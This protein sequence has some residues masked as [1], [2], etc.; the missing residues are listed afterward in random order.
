MKAVF[1]IT[2]TLLALGLNAQF[3]EQWIF[4]SSAGTYTEITAGTILGTAVEGSVGAASLDDVL[5]VLPENT[6][7]WMFEFDGEYYTGLTASTNGQ[8]IIGGSTY[9][10]HNPLSSTVVASGCVAL[11]ARDL[12]GL[13][14]AGTLGEMRYE[15]VGTAPLREFV[16]Q[17]KNF[18]K[19]GTA[20]NNESYNFQLRLQETTNR[21]RIVYGTMTVNTTN[22]S[23][24]VGL[25]GS[26]N[27]DYMGRTTTTDWTQSTAATVNNATMTLTTAVAPTSGLQYDFD[28]AAPSNPPNPAIAIGPIDGTQNVPIQQGLAWA[29][30]GGQTLGYK[31]SFGTDNPPTNIE[32][33]TDLGNVF[34]YQ[35]ASVLAYDTDYFWI[36]VPF[37]EAGDTQNVP[38]WSFRTKPDPTIYQIPYYQSF[39]SPPGALPTDW[40]VLVQGNAS[41]SMDG[42]YVT[43]NITDQADPGLICLSAP[44]LDEDL[45]LTNLRLRFTSQGGGFI[46]VGMISDPYSL[47]SFELIQRIAKPGGTSWIEYIIHFDQYSGTNRMPAFIV[48]EYGSQTIDNVYIETRPLNDLALGTL[49]GNYNPHVGIGE[50]YTLQIR[51]LGTN[52]QTQYQVKLMNGP[53]EL[54]TLPGPPLAPSESALIRIPWTPSNAGNHSLKGVITP[55]QDEV[56]VNN[57]T[58]VMPVSVS[59]DPNYTFVLGTGASYSNYPINLSNRASKY[60]VIIPGQN[61]GTPMSIFALT[62]YSFFTEAAPGSHVKLWLANTTQS[63]LSQ[64]FI[65]VEDFTLVFDGTMNFAMGVNNVF[66]PFAELPQ[67][68]QYTG[69]NL[70]LMAYKSYN[71]LEYSDQNRFA[72]FDINWGQAR[73][74]GSSLDNINPETQGGII[75][76]KAPKIAFHASAELV[77]LLRGALLDLNNHPIPGVTIQLTGNPD[78]VTNQFGAFEFDYLTEGPYTISCSVTGYENYSQQLNIPAGEVIIHNISPEPLFSVGTVAGF[79]KNIHGVAIAGALLQNEEFYTH[80]DAAGNYVLNLPVGTGSITVTAGDYY[81]QTISNVI[82]QEN[83]TTTLNITMIHPTANDDQFAGVPVTSISGNFPN[84]FNPST[85]IEFN[86]AKASFTRLEIYNVKGQL[87]RTLAREELRTGKYELV[88]N[89]RDDTGCEVSSG[90]YF[91]KLSHDGKS[92]SRKMMLMK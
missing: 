23:P 71:V 79:V 59:N 92:Y 27:A 19:Y 75:V 35:P 39:N 64:G 21:I 7:P 8:V 33:A 54:V 80:S 73:Y 51:N 50:I 17:W 26:S 36:I 32:N 69:G 24:Q 16:I 63:D 58:P 14:T 31:I 6:I 65:P 77:G 84:P 56:T 45:S 82:V 18:K 66:F 57:S 20:N 83:Q 13:V 74:L 85:T 91:V 2:L 76:D 46:K 10:G 29:S 70:A 11:V 52:P 9:L 22:G 38:V 62:L 12:Q 30:G 81:P 3:A 28:M 60:Q 67:A 37:N 15:V 41:V 86:L 48:D 34:S 1:L 89:G 49:G 47:D 88:W 42:G 87:V 4:S 61:I 44:P 25:R 53:S 78:V 72:S 90:I 40:D 55:S 5:Y 68:F 43:M